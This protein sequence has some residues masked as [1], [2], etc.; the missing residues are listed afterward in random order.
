LFG[1]PD[2]N[3]ALKLSAIYFINWSRI[4]AQI[5]YYFYSYF[6]LAKASSS[7]EI[8]DSVRVVIPTGNFGNIHA[9]YFAKK[10]GLPVDKL[11]SAFVRISL[12]YIS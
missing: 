5:I 10:M 2:T 1:N 6:S 3:H 8:E 11:L 4:L 9:G 7:F 12:C